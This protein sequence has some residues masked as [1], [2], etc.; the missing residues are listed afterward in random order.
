MQKIVF[1]GIILIIGLFSLQYSI[2]TL[3]GRQFSAN[4]SVKIPE[5]VPVKLPVP[6][7]K[8]IYIYPSDTVI[9]IEL[10]KECQV[11]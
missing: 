8:V 7:C 9:R 10:P 3:Y 6:E 2:A 1:V 11:L 5:L 4:N